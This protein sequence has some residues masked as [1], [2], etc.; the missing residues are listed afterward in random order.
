V[1]LINDSKTNAAQFLAVGYAGGGVAPLVV[2]PAGLV[3]T[4]CE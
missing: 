4:F 1:L 3:V 2:L